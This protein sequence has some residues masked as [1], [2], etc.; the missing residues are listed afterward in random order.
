ML[1]HKACTAAVAAILLWALHGCAAPG[2]RLAF[3]CP[4]CN[5]PH[6]A[7]RSEGVYEC[8]A[9]GEKFVAKR[10]RGCGEMRYAS[11]EAI[12]RAGCGNMRCSSCGTSN[13]VCHCKNCHSFNWAEG[14]ELPR[15]CLYCGAP[16]PSR[17]D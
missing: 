8:P 3:D 2:P 17:A 7:L 11:A 13:L 4:N 12:A 6:A 16:L 5:R 9:C 14:E 1:R 15:S 10:C